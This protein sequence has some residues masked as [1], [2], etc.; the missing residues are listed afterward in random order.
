VALPIAVT[1]DPA[2]ARAVVATTLRRY[3]ELENYRRLLEIEGAAGPA[4]IAIVGDE[5]AVARQLEALAEAGATDFLASIFPVGE[6]AEASVA[7]TWECLRRL[8]P[9]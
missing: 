9:A 4:D 8:N 6:A 5:A 1:D 7:R 2:A 3:G